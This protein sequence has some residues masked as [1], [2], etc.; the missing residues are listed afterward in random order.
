MDLARLPELTRPNDAEFL[1]RL[2]EGRRDAQAELFVRHRRLVA[3]VL[4][5][6]LGNDPD[7]ADLVQDVFCQAFNSA[8]NYRGDS[9]GLTSW[10][11]RIAIFVACGWIRR[12]AVRRRYLLPADHHELVPAHVAT[13][14][15]IEELRRVH[16]IFAKLPEHERAPLVL[17][18]TSD[19]PIREIAKLCGT[20]LSTLQRRLRRARARFHLLVAQDP[21]LRGG[22]IA[23]RPARARRAAKG[24]GRTAVTTNAAA[25]SHTPRSLTNG[26]NAATSASR[27]AGRSAGSLP[28]IAREAGPIS[29]A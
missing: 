15:Q 19:L 25:P 3:R 11:R 7:I 29:S 18:L 2:R 21:A 5:R 4:Q 28:S 16:A 22:R 27:N 20:S 14:E 26:L 24:Q 23:L 17:S 12:S 13:P 10:I 6:V 9:P 1:A 8:K